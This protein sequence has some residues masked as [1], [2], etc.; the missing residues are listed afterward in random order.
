MA[1]GFFEA[2]FT[3]YDELHKMYPELIKRLDDRADS[4]R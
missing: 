1:R 4:I 2:D 3:G